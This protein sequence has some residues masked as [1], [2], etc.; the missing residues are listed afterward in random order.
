MKNSESLKEFKKLNSQLSTLNFQL[1]TYDI[2][3]FLDE[4]DGKL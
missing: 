2:K 3:A 1:V 4:S